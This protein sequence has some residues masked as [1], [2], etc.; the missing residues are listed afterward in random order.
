MTADELYALPLAEFTAARNALAAELRKQGDRAA[1]DEAKALAKPSISAWALNQVARRQPKLVE[2][3]L[4]AAEDLRQAQQRLL[5]GGGQAK[6]REAGQA[7]RKAA[8]ALVHA[9]A[10]V[11][12]EDGH[13]AGKSMLD[14]LEATARAASADPEAAELLRAGR[15]VAD[16]NPA[17][18]G[19]LEAGPFG[20]PAAPIPFPKQKAPPA[21]SPAA[22]TR[23]EELARAREDVHRLQHELQALRQQAGEAE[24]E[25]ARARQAA[26]RAEREWADARAAAA[27]AEDAA[28]RAHTKEADAAEELAAIRARLDRTADELAQAEDALKQL[29]G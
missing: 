17:G 1:S 21:P 8:A 20:L 10:Q 18:F 13:P 7:E 29:R 23:Q 25:A 12:A 4:S 22:D 11:L 26:A 5:A 16:L 19:G 3:L 24:G 14:R 27:K 15:L 28:K 9:A 6:F 2:A